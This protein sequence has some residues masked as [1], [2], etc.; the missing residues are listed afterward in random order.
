MILSEL[1]KRSREI[2][3]HIVDAYVETGE[4]VGSKTLSHLLG[5]SL[6]PATIRGV[7]ADLE[8][9]GLL[10]SP[11]TS[12]GRVPTDEGLRFFV[13]GLLEMGDVSP[14]ER[15]KIAQQCQTKGK[16][17][18]QVLEETTTALSGLTRCAGLV[19]APK[20]ESVLKHIEFVSL[21][22]G[23]ILVVLITH[24][25][26]VEN[27]IV[28]FPPHTPLP[29]LT[30]ITNYLNSHLQGLTL[31]QVRENIQKTLSERQTELDLLSSQ[32][33][34]EG[35][36]VW[37]GKEGSSTALIV[38]GQSHLLQDIRHMEDLERL[39]SLFDALDTQEDLLSLLDAS[40]QAEGVQIFIGAENRF[41]HYSGCALIVAPYA[42]ETGRV[43]GAIGVI[44]PSRMRYQRIIP[45]VDY[46]AKLIGKT[47]S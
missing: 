43:V 21:G 3:R 19:I 46:T 26:M 14:E 23:R 31:S 32:V 4:P 16:S 8:E 24:D 18:E 9:A 1:N 38:R 40:I 41:F 29:D 35:L 34:Q 36:A 17:L 44:G 28:E 12:A 20:S 30:Q 39:K 2:F 6:S 5:L 47:L 7:M 42:N 33:V 11:H 45:M 15:D 37:G 13:H 27:R 25:G 10:Y 22:S